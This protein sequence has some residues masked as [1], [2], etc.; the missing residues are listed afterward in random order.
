MRVQI[1]YLSIGLVCCLAIL[2]FAQQSTPTP[3]IVIQGVPSEQIPAG[4]CT[5]STF[6]Y[7]EFNGER[8]GFTD[9]E[10]GKAIL[11]AL[12]QGYVLTIYPSTKSGIFINQE[13]HSLTK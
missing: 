10:F 12:R 7:V 4:T 3:N 6:G 5:S 8:S 1:R 2:L 13:C 11:S 9:A